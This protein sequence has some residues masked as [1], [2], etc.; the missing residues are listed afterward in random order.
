MYALLP[1]KVQKYKNVTTV[2]WHV[3]FFIHGIMNSIAYCIS[4]LYHKAFNHIMVNKS[5]SAE[6]LQVMTSSFSENGH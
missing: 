3:T 5:M 1:L 6:Q 2:K 4:T